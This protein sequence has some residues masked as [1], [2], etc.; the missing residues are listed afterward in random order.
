MWNLYGNICM[1]LDLTSLRKERERD[2][3]MSCVI[4]SHSL[5]LLINLACIPIEGENKWCYRCGGRTGSLKFKLKFKHEIF[6]PPSDKQWISSLRR[7]RGE[8]P[9]KD[10]LYVMFFVLY[11]FLS[12]LCVLLSL[13]F[14]ATNCSFLFHRQHKKKLFPHPF[15]LLLHWCL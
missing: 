3:N 13:L 7:K 12:L 8:K 15:F 10:H 1:N 14:G 6:R 4:H 9:P 5:S 11:S 2:S